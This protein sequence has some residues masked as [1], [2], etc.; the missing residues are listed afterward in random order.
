MKTS[1]QGWIRGRAQAAG[2]ASKQ[3]GGVGGDD[4]VAKGRVEMVAAQRIRCTTRAA[5]RL[6]CN[7]DDCK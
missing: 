4:R 1:R 6:I 3:R 7:G 2:I 5:A